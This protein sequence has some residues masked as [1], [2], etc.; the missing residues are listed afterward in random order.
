MEGSANPTAALRLYIDT[1]ITPRLAQAL[2]AAGY[3]AVSAYELGHA[4]LADADHLAFAAA[5]GRALLSCNAR[6]FTPLF[7]DYW[8]AGRGHAGVIVSEQLEF[9][10][11]LRRV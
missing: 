11:L 7:E 8:F 6:D 1:D 10:E 3:D 9:G 4:H 5:E 2:R